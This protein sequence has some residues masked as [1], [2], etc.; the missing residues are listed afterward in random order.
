MTSALA[1]ESALAPPAVL[2]LCLIVVLGSNLSWIEADP[3]DAGGLPEE[4]DDERQYQMVNWYRHCTC[5]AGRIFPGLN[6]SKR[7]GRI[8]KFHTA[9]NKCWEVPNLKIL[10]RN[11]EVQP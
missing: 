4:V 11:K 1:W 2:P 10:E 3:G 7:G 8:N 5:C 6:V 9:Q